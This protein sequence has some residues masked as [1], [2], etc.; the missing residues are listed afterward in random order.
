M[1][2]ENLRW[3]NIRVKHLGYDTPEQR[4]KKFEFYQANDHFKTKADIGFDDYSHLI[5]LNPRLVEYK[6][7]HGI[8]MTI[9]V[10]NDEKWIDGCLEGLMWLVDEFIIV[11]TGST[12]GT[13]EIIEK[14]KKH[15]HVPV[16]VFDFPWCDNYSLPRNFAKRQATQPWV[17]FMDCD[18]RFKPE[19]VKDIFNLSENDFDMIMF[20]I[21][22]YL[23][24]P[25]PNGPTKTAPTQSARLFRNIPEFYFTGIVHETIDDS[26]VAFR[27]SKKL[28][29]IVCPATIHHYGYL[30]GKDKLKFKMDYYEKLNKEQIKI[31]EGKDARPYFNMALHYMNDDDKIAAMENFQKSLE[32]NPSMWHAAQQMAMLNMQNTKAFLHQALQY[33][34]SNHPSY[35]KMQEILRFLE[36]NSHG[37]AKVT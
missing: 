30:S 6:A 15:C 8:S 9:M 17:M 37:F 21:N 2:N 19:Q 5:D 35:G 25:N 32:I 34:P 20:N 22:N 29:A 16:K 14:F 36:E 33:M 18:E 10:K 4:Q 3:T 7:D 11:D 28:K 13:R 23:E 12:D 27:I 24:Q 31:T 26:T 1:G